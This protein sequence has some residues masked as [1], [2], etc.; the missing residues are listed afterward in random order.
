[1]TPIVYIDRQTGQTCTEKV[2]G[3][4]ALGF[5]Y[6]DDWLSKVF[7]APLLHL[8]SRFP[9]FS[10]FYGRMQNSSWSKKKVAPFIKNFDMD[11]REFLQSP[12][13]YTSF[14]DFF[15]RKLKVE[16]RPI[17]TG[18]DVAIIPADGRY[19]FFQNINETDG[20][21]VKDQK[22][23]LASLLGSAELAKEYT[24]GSMVIARLCPSDYHRYHFP[25][26]CVPGETH[27][28]NGWLYSVNPIAIRKNIHIFTQNKRTLCL[29]ESKE[30]GQVLFL[31]IGATSVGSIHQTY[32]PD[33]PQ[34]KGDEKGYFAF[35]ASS[36]I[37]L[38]KPGCI[39]FDED[40]LA[41]T[42]KGQEIRCLMGQQMGHTS[43]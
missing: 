40:L 30:F 28:I 18:K 33:T 21:I 37:L 43:S 9:F 16:A 17:A 13:S 26:D 1:M 23:D 27:L 25:I 10:A 15:T 4:K 42:A 29:L 22:F 7:G 20:F 8:L 39:V 3:G 24:H 5:L 6:G 38:F 32:T 34:A 36:L 2:Y 11:P 31:E 35:G 14:N 19:L 41:A 12:E